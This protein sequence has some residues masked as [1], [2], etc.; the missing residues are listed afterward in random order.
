[1][2]RIFFEIL[3]ELLKRPF[4]WAYRRVRWYVKE[5]PYAAKVEAQI[6]HTIKQL[7]KMP[8]KQRRKLIRQMEKRAGVKKPLIKTGLS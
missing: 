4:L 3:W 2:V 8:R 6:E 7:E 5:Q 1:M